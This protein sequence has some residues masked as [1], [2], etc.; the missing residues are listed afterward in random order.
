MKDFALEFPASGARVYLQS[1]CLEV[2]ESGFLLFF[3]LTSIN[4]TVSVIEP[5][6]PESE[7]IGVCR[8]FWANS[9]LLVA[10]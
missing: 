3:F 2:M 9:P 4:A 6:V 5:L 10:D 7:T 8:A 1:E